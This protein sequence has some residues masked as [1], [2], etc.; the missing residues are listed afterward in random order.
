MGSAFRRSTFVTSRLADFADPKRLATQI[1]H[2][3]DE[4]PEVIVKELVDNAL[5][6]CEGAGRAPK[7]GIVVT[8]H[9]IAGSDN[10]K[11]IPAKDVKQI[12]NYATRTSSNA[13]Y[14]SPTRGQQG[15]ALQTLIAMGHAMSGEPGITLIECLGVRHR[16]T[17]SVDPISREPRVT[18]QHEEID[19]ADGTKITI[20]LPVSPQAKI[21]MQCAAVD[22]GWFNPHL[23]L[24]FSKADTDGLTFTH[25]RPR[26]DG[27][28][29]CRPIRPAHT[30]TTA[31]G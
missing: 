24:S 18:H 14:V 12:A 28:N 1:G 16:I 22:F 21:D 20:F 8:D 5:D 6:A 25:S 29:G 19:K 10:G 31:R 9:S 23:S 7:I 15:N 17:F 4:W 2:Q 27:R 11:G 13:A 3:P 26:R 30:G